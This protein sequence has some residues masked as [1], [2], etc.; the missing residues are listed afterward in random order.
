[1]A[2]SYPQQCLARPTLSMCRSETLSVEA[3]SGPEPDSWDVTIMLSGSLA[4]ERCKYK[5]R[6]K[7]QSFSH[8]TS[9]RLIFA[10]TQWLSFKISHLQS[11][12]CLAAHQ[13]FRHPDRKIFWPRDCS[14]TVGL[15]TP[16]ARPQRAPARVN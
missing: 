15:V 12:K 3:R 6:T 5:V 4:A 8:R 9:A 13:S 14:P 16:V 11:V 2:Q 7:G 1:M 10:L